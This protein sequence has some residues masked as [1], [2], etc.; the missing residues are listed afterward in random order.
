MYDTARCVCGLAARSGK[1][2]LII[3][4]CNTQHYMDFPVCEDSAL[5]VIKEG[6]KAYKVRLNCSKDIRK[7]KFFFCCQQTQIFSLMDPF[8]VNF[9]GK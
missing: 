5:K 8:M 4:A 1:D 2:V 9:K 7:V 3:D 6:D